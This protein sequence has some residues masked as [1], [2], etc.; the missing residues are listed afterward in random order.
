V[1]KRILIGGAALIVIIIAALVIWWRM[2][3]AP[4]DIG[5]LEAAY[6]TEQDRYVESSGLTWRVREQGPEDAP[7]V[8]LIHGFGVSL[9][10]FDLLA[11]DLSADHRVVRF[12]LP[13]HA[14]TGPDPQARYSNAETVTLVAAL[15]DDLGVER[16]TLI[17]NSLGGLVAW[18][19][20]A[21]YPERTQAI[22]LISPGGYPI[23]G[24][25]EQ[26]AEVPAPV[27]FYLTGATESLVGQA[28][29]QMYA[30]PAQMPESQNAR[31]HALMRAP[32][33]GEALIQRLEVFTLPDPE[34][35]LA[36]IDAPA[37]ILWGQAD[38]MVPVDHAARFEAAIPNADLIVYDSVG[39]IPQLEAPDRVSADIRDFLQRT[40]PGAP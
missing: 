2:A 1:V 32:G 7:I 37:L 8:T 28:M 22:V 26:A 12:D 23:N 16:S 20:A 39:H 5:A 25:T 9:E 30:D 34:P 4:E 19:Y 27:R 11:E 24:V 14:L 13:G 6:F 36:R 18:R 31:V 3:S 33:V 38:V 35:D 15:L 29:A 10:S 17:G 21:D 40:G